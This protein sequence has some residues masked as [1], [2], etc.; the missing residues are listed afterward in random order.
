MIVTP[1][2]RTIAHNVSI[3]VS[4]KDEISQ[5]VNGIG[6]EL[7]LS[8]LCAAPRFQFFWVILDRP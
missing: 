6:L 3:V 4:E 5:Y 8:N 7:K 2:L 1:L